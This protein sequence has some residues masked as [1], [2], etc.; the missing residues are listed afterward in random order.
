MGKGDGD[1][2][3]ESFAEAASQ[4]EAR[5]VEAPD[6]ERYRGALGLAYAGL[7]RSEDALREVRRA[8]ELMP[9]TREAWRGVLRLGELAAVHAWSGDADSAIVHLDT[10]LSRPGE[11]TTAILR[12][13]PMWDALRDHHGFEA[14][15]ARH[16]AVGE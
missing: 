11:L 15:L 12:H 4:L 10:L 13:D 16:E 5:L 2:A 7:G 3:R 6:D 9:V 8:V 1:A 14:L